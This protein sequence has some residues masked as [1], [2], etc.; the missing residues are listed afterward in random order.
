[1]EK[2][3]RAFIVELLSSRQ[4]SSIRID[5]SADARVPQK[6]EKPTPQEERLAN[7]NG[8]GTIVHIIASLNSGTI[9]YD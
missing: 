9:S 2:I 6:F 7:R 3:V 4:T 8:T 1:M 5:G